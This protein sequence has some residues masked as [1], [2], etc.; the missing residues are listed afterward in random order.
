MYPLTLALFLLLLPAL[1]L[2]VW[3]ALVRRVSAALE[4]L[5]P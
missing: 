2:G 1:A 3:C 5:E 4:A